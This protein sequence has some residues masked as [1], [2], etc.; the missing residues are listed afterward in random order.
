MSEHFEIRA[1]NVREVDHIMP[2]MTCA[3]DS[4]FNEA[5]SR[6]Q[7]IGALIMPG[8]RLISVDHENISHGFAL[9]RTVLDECELLLIGVSPEMRGQGL[10]RQLIKYVM[11]EARVAGVRKLFLEV[12]ITNSALAFYKQLH[13]TVIGERPNYYVSKCGERLNAL[14]MGVDM[15]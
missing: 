12:R 15:G 14:T 13:F 8:T 9:T 6:D 4:D 5:W 11:I 1:L 10:G 7:V 2:V 3:F